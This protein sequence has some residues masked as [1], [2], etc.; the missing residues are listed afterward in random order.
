MKKKKKKSSHAIGK[1]HCG[2]ATWKHTPT[3]RGF[4][5]YLGYLQAQGDYYKHCV[6]IPG[7]EALDGLGMFS[8]TNI[9][10]IYFIYIYFFFHRFLG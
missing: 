5:T 10:L 3:G 9:F 4:K 7:A 1:W 2:Y 8:N 6:S